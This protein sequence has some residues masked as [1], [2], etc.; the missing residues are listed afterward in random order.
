ME[1]KG[2]FGDAF[3]KCILIFALLPGTVGVRQSENIFFSNSHFVRAFRDNA[4]GTRFLSLRISSFGTIVALML[5]IALKP[6]FG[7]KS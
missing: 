2:G 5:I 1:Y 4:F 6:E 3:C 7:L